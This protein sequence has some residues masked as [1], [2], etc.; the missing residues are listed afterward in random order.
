M[1][2]SHLSKLKKTNWGI[3]IVKERKPSVSFG[4]PVRNAEKHIEKLIDSI[5]KQTFQ[6]FEIVIADNVSTDNTR[7]ILQKYASKDDRIRYYFN[8]TN[9]G[10]IENFN[11]VFNLS[12]GKF[13]RWIGADD[14]LEPNYVEDC[15]AL[16]EAD[17]N[18]IGVTTFTVMH[19][20]G[21]YEY[22]FE[23][24]GERLESKD[25][26]RRLSMLMWLLS[27]GLLYLSPIS[28]IFRRNALQKTSLFQ[29]YSDTDLIMAAEIALIGPFGHVNKHLVHRWR[30]LTA[31]TKMEEM[32]KRYH[33]IRYKEVQHSYRRSCMKILAMVWQTEISTAQKIICSIAVSR[34]FLM[35]FPREVARKL[36]LH[37]L[38]ILPRES[39]LRKALDKAKHYAG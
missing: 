34:F 28:A 27:K 3:D 13:F 4:I 15:V 26:S 36:K 7:E 5:L 23:Y 39:K 20:V 31:P 29:I 9:I 12:R 1:D 35:K 32:Y 2:E 37:F 6:D 18:L 33:P 24:L 16:M 11:L 21:G 19:Q 30:P 10:Q 8:E 22:R 25:P 38:S 17:P 14:W